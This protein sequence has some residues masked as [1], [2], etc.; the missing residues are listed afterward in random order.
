M[1][2]LKNLPPLLRR[3]PPRMKREDPEPER[4]KRRYKE[5]PWRKWYQSSDWKRLRLATFE[6]D[7]YICQRTGVMCD[8]SGN[9]DNSPVCNHKVPHRGDRSLFYDPGNLECVS[10][11]AHDNLIQKEEKGLTFR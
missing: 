11:W 2:R 10:K 4:D 9:D 8:G 6:R 5:Q 3:E 1:P 7:G